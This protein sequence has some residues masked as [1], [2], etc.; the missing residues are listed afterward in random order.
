MKKILLL[1]GLSIILIQ[2]FNVQAVNWPGTGDCAGSLLACIAAQS[3][4][5]YV[6]V[7]TNSIA[8]D[9][10]TITLDQNFTLTAGI[11]FHPILRNVVINVFVDDN[12][13]V[14]IKG[15]E[16]EQASLIDVDI[17]SDAELNILSNNWSSPNAGPNETEGI[18]VSSTVSG[19]SESILNIVGNNIVGEGYNFSNRGFI[20]LFHA[21]SGTL[22][23]N[24]IDNHITLLDVNPNNIYYKGLSLQ[25]AASGTFNGIIVGNEIRGGHL[26]I[27]LD[28]NFV[29]SLN[30]GIISNLLT[31]V[32][33]A[34]NSIAT[35]PL[36]SAI[37]SSVG[38]GG[39]FTGIFGNNT[40]DGVK[41]VGENDGI[42]FNFA[43]HTTTGSSNII[44]LN[45]IVTNTFRGYVGPTSGSSTNVTSSG[46]NIF[47]H[48]TA[49]SGL[50][51]IGSDL[52]GFNADPKFIEEGINY[53]LRA[54]S[55]AIDRQNPAGASILY[56][57]GFMTDSPM[58]D[59]DG[60]RRYKGDML[61][62]GAYEWGDRHLLHQAFSP[63][64]NGTIINDSGLDA[65]TNA[66]P[67]VT[68]LWN[69]AG[70]PPVYND[71]AAGIYQNGVADWV[72]FNQNNTVDMPVNAKFH[73]YYPYGR[74]SDS[75][76]GLSKWTAPSSSA[77]GFELNDL[78]LNNNSG[79]RVFVTSSFDGV[80]N[81]HP[82]EIGYKTSNGMWY[83]GN[84]DGF[85]MQAGAS[86]FTYNQ[87]A[88]RNVFRHTATTDNTV[89]HITIID[90]PL[91]NGNPCALPTV[92]QS[93]TWLFAPLFEQNPHNISVYYNG[94][95]WKIFNQDFAVIDI[96]I[97]STTVIGGRFNVMVD[98]Q[99]VYGCNDVIFKN[100][101]E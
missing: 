100:N 99:Q 58:I 96:N 77:T 80:Y 13:R 59:A 98:P 32:I 73:I 30:V 15:F 52:T 55:P 92:T 90:H 84:A 46:D 65:N 94:G 11:G 5:G 10:E 39:N 74:S 95:R 40:I 27:F 22:F 28:Q 25:N 37:S 75:L 49:N 53:A 4:P 71:Q 36:N 97:A 87:D 45:N 23:A 51:L 48:H 63:L 101:F 82:L 57:T 93:T 81:P 1:T 88:S 56:G 9:A 72:I 33:D 3:D 62:S 60:L 42:G 64:F 7:K 83:L 24:I 20:N 43:G 17:A 38:D 47:W 66:I 76:N 8:L 70:A 89:G 41:R 2:S 54:S 12:E 16:F 35:N 34:N 68:Q 86:F 29:G 19:S 26:Q 78:F 50:S 31:G 79:A 69:Y 44:I 14:T 21:S 18:W 91:L 6:T 61:D 85:N 67:I